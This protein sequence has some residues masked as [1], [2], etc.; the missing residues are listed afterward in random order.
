MSFHKISY[1]LNKNHYKNTFTQEHCT[2]TFKKDTVDAW[3]HQRMYNTLKPL[4]S[5]NPGSSWLTIGDG[6]YGKDSIMLKE[7]GDR[8]DALPSDIDTQLLVEAQKKKLISEFKEENAESLSFTDEQFDFTLC[9]EAYHHFPRPMIA[10]YEMLRVSKKAIVLIEPND[11]EYMPLFRHI[12]ISSRKFIKKLLGIKK[13]YHLDTLNYEESGNYKYSI[14]KR[15][16]EKVALG[17]QLPVIA[18]KYF[19]DYYESGVENELA[20]A[21]S[22]LF[23]KVKKKI[24]WSDFICKLTIRHYGLMTTIIFKKHPRDITVKKL[25]ESGFQIINLP[26][27]PYLNNLHL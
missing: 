14:S 10:L 12:N 6:R 24:L 18:Y 13:F 23:K 26:T 9:K 25:S 15:E 5:T 8:I 4:I 7:M 3:R 17:L 22:K 27:N 11:F 2:T 16:I 19:N 20:N 1:D 21:N